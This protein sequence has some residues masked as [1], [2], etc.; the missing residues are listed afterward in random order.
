[1]LDSFTMCLNFKLSDRI[2]ANKTALKA[3][4]GTIL[5]E[6]RSSDTVRG[7]TEWKLWR[8][9]FMTITLKL[10]LPHLEKKSQFNIELEP[11]NGSQFTVKETF[12]AYQIL[13]LRV[14]NQLQLLTFFSKCG[15]FSLSVIVINLPRHNFHSVVPRIMLI[16]QVS[17]STVP[18]S[19][20]AILLAGTRLLCLKFEHIVNH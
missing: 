8:V 2:R 5:F 11:T 3:E 1:M 14:I 7:T 17:N 13:Q 15:R 6:T 20:S 12:T 9:K 18:P 10:N 16:K 19:V 4:G